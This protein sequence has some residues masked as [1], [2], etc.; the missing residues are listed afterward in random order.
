MQ[1]IVFHLRRLFYFLGDAVVMPFSLITRLWR[2]VGHGRLLLFGL[3]SVILFLVATISALLAFSSDD[4]L[5]RKYEAALKKAVKEKNISAQIV[6]R[7][8]LLQLRPGDD[9]RFELALTLLSDQNADTSAANLQRGF[10]MID[11]LAPND[12]AGYYR[13]HLFQADRLMKLSAT[14]RIDPASMPLLMGEVRKQ[15]DYALIGSPD[16]KEALALKAM[17]HEKEEEYAEALKIYKDLFAEDIGWYPKIYECSV[18]LNDGAGARYYI[19]QAIDGYKELIESN[20]GQIDYRRKYANACV[21]LSRFDEAI[22]VL[23]AGLEVP[24]LKPGVRNVVLESLCNVYIS[25]TLPLTEDGEKFRSDA[26]LRQKFLDDIIKAYT[27]YPDSITARQMLVRFAE[28]GYP[29][30]ETA[31]QAYDPR[32]NVET[33]TD[34]ELEVIGTRELLHGNREAGIGFLQKGLEKNPQNHV[35]LNNLAYALIDTD[36]KRARELVIKAIQIAPNVPNYRDTYGN[37][38]IREGKY[39]EA[40]AELDRARATMDGSE[41]LHDALALCYD[42][43]GL[44]ELSEMHKAKA[45]E[46]RRSKQ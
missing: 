27:I 38:L 20:P 28:S 29:E 7:Q 17:M 15:I 24:D 34:M 6:Y 33:A 30:S 35:I 26:N 3:P 9:N 12:R 1:A 41:K 39:M 4:A 5:Y 18:A 22:A 19:E 42:K 45:E 16:S 25:R 46:I 21:M 40:I 14:Q 44:T 2:D 43:V 37:L 8:K 31:R 11:A 13:A 32:V 10:A 23:E 36:I